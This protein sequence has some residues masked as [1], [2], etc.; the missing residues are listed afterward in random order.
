MTVKVEQ[1]LLNRQEE[2]MQERDLWE[3]MQG[4]YSNDM[5]FRRFCQ[6]KMDTLDGEAERI[7]G[8]LEGRWNE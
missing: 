6:W 1:T 4:D 5:D 7:R 2:L 8:I 3:D